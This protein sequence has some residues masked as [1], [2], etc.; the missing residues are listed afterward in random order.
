M[1]DELRAR[2]DG[3][4]WAVGIIGAG[5]LGLSTA[6]AL[7]E[8]GITCEMF[9]PGA[10]GGGQSRGP[11]HV[12][13]S[14]SLDPRVLRLK[15]ASRRIW[16]RWGRELGAELFAERGMVL[17]GSG[18]AGAVA[19]LSRLCPE[20]AFETLSA[21]EL[22]GILP[23]EDGE[24]EP[25]L[26]DRTGMVIW[27]QRAIGLLFE[28]L[29][30]PLIPLRVERIEIL[31]DGRAAVTAGEIRREYDAVVVAAGLSTPALAAPL[32][33]DI[34]AGNAA[35]VYGTFRIRGPHANRDMAAFV[36]R[37]HHGEYA[38]GA[39]LRDNLHYQVTLN[40]RMKQGEREQW[41]PE[42]TEASVANLE[43][44]VEGALPRLIPDGAKVGFGRIAGLSW[45]DRYGTGIGVWR[46]GPVIFPAGAPM[47]PT[48]PALGEMLAGTAEGEPVPPEFRPESRFG[49]VDPDV[50]EKVLSG[51]AGHA[52]PGLT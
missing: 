11:V 29:P 46:Q 9:E 49:L 5:I 22:P 17:F 2:T 12:A 33:V 25:A 47:F 6:R 48:G 43:E 44:W 15:S 27:S 52:D 19:E 3:E 50:Q 39:P 41:S 24:T 23:V 32:G 14:G 10:P 30:G 20:S 7:A 40:H 21:D 51:G 18:V 1:A 42:A 16:T 31:P 38:S 36:G 8:R 34:P 13:S 28:G 26:L 45:A 4:P 35:R 37:N